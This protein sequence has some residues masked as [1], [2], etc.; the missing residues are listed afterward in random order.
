MVPIQ[1]VSDKALIR[2]PRSTAD[3]H[4]RCYGIN[5]PLADVGMSVPPRKQ[6]L[7]VHV[8]IHPGSHPEIVPASR[9]GPSRT[10]YRIDG[11]QSSP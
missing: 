11:Y 3:S 4:I 8:H 2:K 10:D 6:T 5:R 7:S 1:L 9:F